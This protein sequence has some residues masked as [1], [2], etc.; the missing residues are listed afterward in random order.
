[1][2]DSCP[3]LSPH[4]SLALQAAHPSLILASGSRIRLS[5]LREAGLLVAAKPAPIDEDCLK[6]AAQARGAG[7]DE[8][9]LHLADRKA[10][11]VV[12]PGALVIGADQL[13]VCE[14]QWFD[15]PADLS[16]A[17]AHLLALR[18]RTH[19]LHTAVSL[20]RDGGMIWQHVAWPRLTM[21]AFSDAALDAYLALE[22]DRVLSSVGAYRLEGPG[23]HLFEAI[24]GEHAAILGLP[25]LA[26]LGALRQH[27][28]LL[29]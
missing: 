19:V 23:I 21:R 7:P 11:H 27:G 1:M 9:A 29:R 17:R 3:V 4:Q 22:G 14:E 28:L 15:K 13:L 25:L 16:A 20:H 24:E 6:R 26:L 2:S 12:A 8:T 10:G 18:G 5:L